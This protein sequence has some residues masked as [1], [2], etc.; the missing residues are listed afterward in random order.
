MSESHLLVDYLGEGADLQETGK[1]ALGAVAA[2]THGI[3]GMGTSA[4]KKKSIRRTLTKLKW[5]LWGWG[6]ERNILEGNEIWNR[7]KK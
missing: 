3:W 4:W 1:G 6:G 7:K 5:F 2:N